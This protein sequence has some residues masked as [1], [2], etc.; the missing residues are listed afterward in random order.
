TG[1]RHRLDDLAR[2]GVDRLMVVGLEPDAD[3]LSRHGSLPSRPRPARY[4]LL[5][6]GLFGLP[7]IAGTPSCWSTSGGR[8]I[9]SY[10]CYRTS[11]P[12]SRSTRSGVSRP[13]RRLIP[14]DR[15]RATRSSWSNGAP[16]TW[17]TTPDS[18]QS[19]ARDAHSGAAD[20]SGALCPCEI[21]RPAS[22]NL[23]RMPHR[24]MASA[25]GVGV[26]LDDLGDL[27]GANGTATLT[28][29]APQALV[30]SDRLDQLNR[31]R[32]VVTRHHHLGALR[33]RHDTRHVRGPEVELRTVVVEERRVAAT[34]VL[35]QDV[36][37]SL[38]LGV[39]GG[40]A[41][42]RHNLTT[43]HVLAL[44]TTQQQ[45]G[46]VTGLAGVQHLVEHL[47]AGDGGLAGLGADTDDLDLFVQ[48]DLTALDPA[49]RRGR[50]R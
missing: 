46:V 44:D 17:P 12:C 25:P 14:Q 4:R 48:L 2:A 39:R 42:L 10:R 19:R 26:L 38:E 23:D 11:A 15:C 16:A 9:V 22:S 37:R 3:L 18:P 21:G 47:D 43:L 7:S 41:R 32:G 6:A 30:H 20:F 34:L 28:D 29:G 24:R 45:G 35:R 13:L 5:G 33:Q 49:E 8:G 40:G 27:A 36:H 50:D 1:A 31:D